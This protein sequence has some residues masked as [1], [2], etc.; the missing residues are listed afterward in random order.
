MPNVPKWVIG[1]ERM[2]MLSPRPFPSKI[3][4]LSFGKCQGGNVRG[5]VI[6]F[7]TFEEMEKKAEDIKGKIVFF[8]G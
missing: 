2:T 4:M 1:E 8:Q 6:M 7:E 5:E 3:Q